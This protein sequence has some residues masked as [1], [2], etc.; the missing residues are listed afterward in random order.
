MKR[1]TTVIT[2]FNKYGGYLLAG[3]VLWGL[4]RVSLYEFLLFH[5][6]VEIFSIVIA[7]GIFALA[8]NSRRWLDNNTLLFLGIAYLFIGGLDLVHTLAYKGMGIFPAP[9]DGADL[10]TQLWIGTRYL[11]ALSLLVAPWFLKRRLHPRA[12]LMG[13]AAITALLLVSIFTG[14]FP[15]CYI[16]GVG[17][18]PFKQISEYVISLIFLG[19]IV[20][21]V[22][23][24]EAFN[25]EV[26]RF[27]IFS[28][29]LT[30]ASELS[31]AF[32]S[33]V[34]GFLN[35]VGH[36]FKLAAFYFAYKAII[37]RGLAQPYN[38]LFR[39][40]KGSQVALR[41]ER[42]RAQQYL[43]IVGVI[44]VA[45]DREQRV[46]LINREGCRILGRPESEILGQ[47]WFD[48]Y[49]PAPMREE[50]RDAFKQ[51][52]AGEI[53]P[54]RTFENP[55][56]TAEGEVRLIA[57]HNTVLTDDAGN[58]TGT[59][60]SGEDITERQEAIDQLAW[61]SS[62]NATVAMLSKALISSSSL[63]E[64]ST[65]VLEH[66]QRVTGSRFGFVGYIDPASG[67]L[68]SP[69]LTHDIWETCQVPD[70]TFVFDMF[71]GLW[72]WVLKHR[73][74]LLTNAPEEDARSSG[75]P[76]G[77]IPIER[78]LGVP[79]L[80]DE[81]L[82]G[83]VALANPERDYTAQDLAFVER[84][85]S[86]YALAVQR[87]RGEDALRRAKE[88]AEAA[89]RAKSVFLAN[90]SHELRTPLNAILGFSQLIANNV[91][92]DATQQENLETV[93]RSGEHLLSLI[94]DV[95]AM[96]KIEAGRVT[97][98]EQSFDLHRLLQ[99]LEEMFALRAEAKG[100]TLILDLA[101]DTPRYVHTDEGKLRQILMNLL[102]NAVKF[103]QEGGVTLRVG[104]K[105]E[106]S[107]QGAADGATADASAGTSPL[108][109]CFEVEDT[110]AGIA[111]EELTALFDP[112]V[113]TESG[114]ASQEG[115][116]LGLPICQQFV[117]L[118]G[119]ELRVTS[120]VGKGSLFKFDIPARAVD[121]AEV[122][123]MAQRPRV[124]A[125]APG[126]PT[127]RLLVVEDRK[128]NRKLLTRLLKPLGFK[129]REATHGQEAINVWQQ[130]N[131]HL[132]FMDLRMPVMNG[133]EATRRIKATAKGQATVI[134]ALTASAFEE[135]RALVLS[136]GCD[137]FVSKPF[138][139]QELFDVL[140]RHLGVRFVYETEHPTAAADSVEAA[141][142]L[143]DALRAL[144]ARWRADLRRAVVR[145]NFTQ[146]LD[147]IA[148]IHG[149]HPELADT[150]TELAQNFE[151]D[152]L[153]ALI[154]DQA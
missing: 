109:L 83:Q 123:S 141:P 32:Y 56:L 91:R 34:Y 14:L 49:V 103:T 69:T 6:L 52:M 104:H 79:A 94:N 59:L 105:R 30:A 40:L 45:L 20:P 5:S 44:L 134:V 85:A 125:L 15:R 9:W 138:R 82:M 38:L 148:D 86:L 13:Y 71:S 126:Q 7:F 42:D 37:E 93:L 47:R 119:G 36:Y 106:A 63:E 43:D 135:D 115:T 25:R 17:L 2:A 12:T 29:V 68:I 149:Q 11:H 48:T 33:D 139:D 84:L 132:I 154:Q 90:M 147:L 121:A 54:V 65:L 16:P 22:R 39:D 150:L 143:R 28:I 51:L 133:Y 57:W 87:R 102:G 72:G 129:V 89:N 107:V 61:E 80:F 62:V 152:R 145:A 70:K 35:L 21:L 75:T 60:S 153:A 112:F 101:P 58:I 97:L 26:L 110:G 8:W 31:F 27:L 128:T 92:L 73:R 55:V 19:A 100:L 24:R 96:S 74:P 77:H 142:A 127:Y 41:K 53:T 136:E 131:P 50:T 113:Q 18:T 23:Q 3:L 117:S 130:W 114:R 4:Y 144:P 1:K 64:V 120:E 137:D 81:Q 95:L 116:G 76:P 151:Y 98:N 66:A 122:A 78:F 108:T 46:T 124:V 140:E 88:E 111:S 118:L 99:G 10:A 146:M 67:H